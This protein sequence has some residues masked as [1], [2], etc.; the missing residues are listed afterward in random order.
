MRFD[1]RHL[2]AVAL[3]AIALGVLAANASSVETT[4]TIEAVYPR[5]S[6]E[7]QAVKPTRTIDFVNANGIP[8]GIRW[9][10]P[11][12]E[13]KCTGVPVNSSSSSWSG[14]CT[15]S[16]EGTYLFECTVHSFMKGAIY[17]NAS[18]T[19]PA[20]AP[21]VTTEAA[22]AAGESSAILHGTVNPQ[23]QKTTYFFEY[24]STASYGS[25]APVPAGEL[26]PSSTGEAV[27]ATLSALSPGH[28]YHFRLVATNAGGTSD[29]AD[30]S[31]TTASTTHETNPP[32]EPGSGSETT[33]PSGTPTNSPPP[34]S[35]GGSGSGLPATPTE[36]APSPGG[37]AEPGLLAPSPEAAVIGSPSIASTQHGTA[38]RGSLTV[39]RAGAGGSLQVDLIAK[40]TSH[41]RHTHAKSLLAG[42][43]VRRSA[44]A[45]KLS[46]TIALNARAK[47]MLRRQHR[48][49][50]TVKIA[51]TPP[52]GAADSFTRNIVVRQ[53]M[54]HR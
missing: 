45:G 46:F 52:G 19:L 16:Q 4:P 36:A 32:P 28:T 5:W 6:P 11:P 12:A 38:V 26:A 20:A 29:G 22:S 41:T 27:S 43:L 1:T 53:H 33:G 42:R 21:T 48:L 40:A 18:G 31:F 54:G 50:L 9:I 37:G 2:F 51:F 10:N 8:H 25:T 44:P 23:G 35:G 34:P 39:S 24:G 30:R 14:S 3:P 7:Q 47:V 49:A 17:V 13:P 15:F